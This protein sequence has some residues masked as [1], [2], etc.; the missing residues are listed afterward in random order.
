MKIIELRQQDAAI[1][2]RAQK[3][4]G[5]PSIGGQNLLGDERLSL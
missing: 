4:G 3:A 2:L 1:W 5:E